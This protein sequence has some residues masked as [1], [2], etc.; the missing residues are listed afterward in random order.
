MAK[1]RVG[2]RGSAP[3]LA[4]TVRPSRLE[5]ASVPAE[6]VIIGRPAT[7]SPRSRSKVGGKGLFIKGDWKRSLAANEID[8][9]IPR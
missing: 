5:A 2:T 8:L 9:A 6:L 3:A 1:L 4:Q 7:N